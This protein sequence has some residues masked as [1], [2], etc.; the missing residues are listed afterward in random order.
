MIVFE[1]ISLNFWFDIELHFFFGWNMPTL[2]VEFTIG[3]VNRR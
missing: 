2:I 3:Q 1:F